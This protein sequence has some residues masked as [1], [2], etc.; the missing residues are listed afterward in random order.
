M[1]MTKLFTYIE[2]QFTKKY[3][4]AKQ[5]TKRSKKPSNKEHRAK[6]SAHH[7]CRISR[8]SRRRLKMRFVFKCEQIE[9]TNERQIS[10]KESFTS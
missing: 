2:F 6:K 10:S 3:R 9:S 4:V 7:Q 1:K 8:F 5:Q